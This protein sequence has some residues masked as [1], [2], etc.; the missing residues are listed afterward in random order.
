MPKKALLGPTI[1]TLIATV[2]TE[3]PLSYKKTSHASEVFYHQKDKQETPPPSSLHPMREG[4]KSSQHNQTLR[5]K[6]Y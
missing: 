4:F 2:L 6:S 3:N 1:A 5:I